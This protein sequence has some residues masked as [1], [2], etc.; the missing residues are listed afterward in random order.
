MEDA[1]SLGIFLS[2]PK[3]GSC[4]VEARLQKWNE[5]RYARAST[6]QTISINGGKPLESF[7]DKIRDTIGY[8]GPL[9]ENVNLHERPVQEFFFRYDVRKEA[10]AFLDGEV[11]S[12]KSASSQ[13]V[14]AAHTRVDSV[15][16]SP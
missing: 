1:A 6:V 15:T 13:D 12:T 14:E 5:F 10:E 3:L 11:A 4:S 8:Q 16:A 9:P 2:S 7:I